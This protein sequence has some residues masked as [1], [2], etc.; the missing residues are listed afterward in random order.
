MKSN[1]GTYRYRCS[2]EGSHTYI[3]NLCQDSFYWY[4]GCYEVQENKNGFYRFCPNCG[5]ELTKEFSKRNKRW[6][7]N[8]PAKFPKLVIEVQKTITHAMDRGGGFF[9]VTVKPHEVWEKWREIP[10]LYMG[11]GFI[12]SHK[13]VVRELKKIKNIKWDFRCKIVRYDGFAKEVKLGNS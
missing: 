11:N 3:C 8:R 13:E 7:K 9:C 1:K 10:L 12:N 2:D 5:C 4:N 6:Y